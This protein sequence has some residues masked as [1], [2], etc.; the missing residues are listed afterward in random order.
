[1]VMALH[2]TSCIFSSPSFEGKAALEAVS[3]EK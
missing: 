1:M 2:G 3:R